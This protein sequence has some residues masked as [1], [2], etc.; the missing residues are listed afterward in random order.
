MF[1]LTA[2]L[3]AL[4]LA[5]SSASAQ[6][7][8]EDAWSLDLGMTI[9]K[10]ATFH[11]YQTGCDDLL[12]TTKSNTGGNG[13][14]YY[15]NL[16]QR[17]NLV[18]TSDSLL[19]DGNATALD[20]LEDG[21]YTI[22]YSCAERMHIFTGG[23]YSRHR[24]VP[25]RVS[26]AKIWG[27]MTPG[28]PDDHLRVFASSSFKSGWENEASRGVSIGGSISGISLINGN[29]LAEPMDVG[30]VAGGVILDLDEDQTG[31]FYGITRSFY[32]QE[33][34]IFPRN[35]IRDGSENY[36][37]ATHREIIDQELV[38]RGGDEWSE[39]IALIDTVN[40]AGIIYYFNRV[41]R[42]FNLIDGSIIDTL[43]IDPADGN[44]MT[45]NTFSFFRIRDE[46]QVTR[47]LIHQARGMPGYSQSH[48]DLYS[49][50][51][52]FRLIARDTIN[53][54]S[55]SCVGDFDG[56][57]TDEILM[58]SNNV[59]IAKQITTLSIAEDGQHLLPS[60]ISISAY[61]NPFNSTVT[62][63]YSV[64]QASLPVKLTIYDLAGREVVTL[65]NGKQESGR[66]NAIWSA[67]GQTSGLYFVRLE[68]NG[69]RQTIRMLL[70]K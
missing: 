17:G 27:K 16:V 29:C 8:L 39:H 42:R 41:L 13:W 57:G 47:Y 10:K 48:T 44:E 4:V 25:V 2:V 14:K 38:G 31:E 58:T 37:K 64:R 36:I 9:H 33:L 49:I 61:P 50:E 18:W 51:N 46:G 70:L 15:I 52:E 3:L 6:I 28:V 30:A 23:D 40:Q 26:M 54:V 34:L 53:Y 45:P 68:A 12:I 63:S 11:N 59:I 35:T 66:Y 21:S 32:L 20:F 43:E 60:S 5:I 7:S 65:V 22:V 67:T 69:F 24:T 62:I 56:D 55:L 19:E 1:R